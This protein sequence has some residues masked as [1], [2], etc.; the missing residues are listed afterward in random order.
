MK[1]AIV[2]HFG[3]TGGGSRVVRSLIPAIK[4]ANPNNEITY[5]G[6]QDSVMREGFVEEFDKCKIDIKYLS[7][8]KI[9]LGKIIT[10]EIYIRAKSHL[11]SRPLNELLIFMESLIESPL[12]NITREIERLTGGFD[13]IF[14][15][16]PF[17]IDCPQIN[18]P[19]VGIFHD[20]NY[21]YYFSG[22]QTFSANSRRNAEKRMPDWL[23]LCVPIVS[24]N[25]IADEL[26]KFYSFAEK[27]VNVIHLPRLTDGAP[28]N[29]NVAIEVV[30]KLG[31][32]SQYVL[33]P[34]HMVSHK[35]IGPL[36]AAIEILNRNG[37]K[38]KLV[39]TGA[40]TEVVKGV[41]TSIGVELNEHHY[42]V[43][44]LGYVTNKEIDSLI[45]CASVVLNCSLYEAGNGSGVDAWAYGTPV[46]M[47][48]IPS[49]VENLSIL[50]VRALLFDSRSPED[51][52]KNIALILDNPGDFKDE[53]AYSK[54][55]MTKI[56]WDQVGKS[57]LRV[58]EKAVHDFNLSD[59]D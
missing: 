56:N 32:N 10:S 44:G 57:Y 1:I 2:D 48:N 54:R 3:N 58:F 42:D 55:S 36:I 46:A 20:F 37:H 5:F 23:M 43:Y 14:Y 24:S 19:M 45:A 30:K 59:T 8:F 49:F 41:A 15:P 7:S 28:I 6:G 18:K 13:L 40:G 31:V 35:N 22:P 17:H 47:S 33:Y 53:V 52:A 34:T 11:N 4:R 29:R 16:W 50:D 39:L 25:F 12:F 27:K 9:K 26:K 21:K 38:I 51:I